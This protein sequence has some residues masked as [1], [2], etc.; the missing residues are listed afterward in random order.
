MANPLYEVL[1]EIARLDY[2]AS[3]ILASNGL[4]AQ[5]V[6]YAE[7]SFEKATKSV[8]AYYYIMHDDLPENEALSKIRAFGHA[9][10][11]ATAAII[12]ILIDKEK[13]IHLSKGGSENDEFI[14]SAYQNLDEFK[15][16][17]SAQ[18]DL[19]PYFSNV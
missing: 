5:S 8:I 9:I 11:M 14:V 4:I 12:K 13:A 1:L 17:K 19:I 10:K 7:Q 3:K 16:D 15:K 18:E 2:K 6:F